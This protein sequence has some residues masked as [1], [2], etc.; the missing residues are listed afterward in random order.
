MLSFETVWPHSLCEAASPSCLKYCPV[1]K[2]GFLSRPSSSFG[3]QVR[4]SA[5]PLI[6]P[7]RIRHRLP[8][9]LIDS[10][11]DTSAELASTVKLVWNC[12][13]ALKIVGRAVTRHSSAVPIWRVRD[14]T[15]WFKVHS[16]RYDYARSIKTSIRYIRPDFCY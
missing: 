10:C 11:K 13:R 2:Y 12:S 5:G 3:K 9:N 8:S 6:F 4:G 7:Q 1:R 15:H 16:T 14:C